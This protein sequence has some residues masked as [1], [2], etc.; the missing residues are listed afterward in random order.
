MNSV[1]VVGKVVDEPTKQDGSHG[2]K[3]AKIRIAVDKASKDNDT[4]SYEI[5]EVVAFRDLAETKVDV[6]QT[7]AVAGRLAANNYEKDGKSYFNCSIIANNLA[8]I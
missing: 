2:L 1:N 7:V 5:F 3:I 6:G 4:N 8:V